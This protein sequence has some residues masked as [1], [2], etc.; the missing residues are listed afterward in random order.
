M[1]Q[2][3]QTGFNRKATLSKHVLCQAPH[4]SSPFHLRDQRPWEVWLLPRCV[5][6]LA[7]GHLVNKSEPGFISKQVCLFPSSPTV[8]VAACD[9]NSG[10][11]TANLAPSSPSTQPLSMDPWS[12]VYFCPI[13]KRRQLE[14]R[15]E[16]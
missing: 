7:Q 6:Q 8:A 1:R 10:L 14:I 16:E 12:E 2:K 4:I 15:L 13:S 5:K 3:A 11:L 9:S